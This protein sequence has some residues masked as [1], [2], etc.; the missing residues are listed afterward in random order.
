MDSANTIG[1]QAEIVACQFLQQQQL[2]LIIKNYHCRRGEI[3]LIMS[4]NKTLVFIEVR[5]R[6]N[7]RFGSALE[8]VDYKKQA[9]IIITA[10]H[11]LQQNT[12]PF[13]GY[14]FDVIA[15]SPTQQADQIIWVKD[16]FHS[17]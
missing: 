2:K 7:D 16:A 15:I 1:Q 10:E 3:D 13:S 8:S 17:N 5:Y 6:K 14:R 11:Y 9:K 12:H 4:D